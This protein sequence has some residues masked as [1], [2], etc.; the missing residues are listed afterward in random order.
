MQLDG[1]AKGVKKRAWNPEPSTV[2]SSASVS[3]RRAGGGDEGAIV[4][5]WDCVRIC[6]A[7]GQVLASWG[8]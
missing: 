6:P 7:Q 4:F 8:S 3:L 5:P 1:A 2:R